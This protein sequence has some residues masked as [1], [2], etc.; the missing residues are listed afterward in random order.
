MLKITLIGAHWGRMVRSMEHACLGA[1]GAALGACRW[2]VH[3]ITAVKDEVQM[4]SY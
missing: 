1:Y 4:K 2:S 3:P